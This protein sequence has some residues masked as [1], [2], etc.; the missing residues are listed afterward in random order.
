MY[1]VSYWIN[2]LSN[3]LHEAAKW[4][5]I[6]TGAAMSSIVFLQVFFRFVI[7]IPFPWSEEG[8]RYLMIWMG[9]VGAA[10]AMR[11]GRHIGV[12]VLIERLPPRVC[13]FLSP[14]TDLAMVAFLVVMAKEGFRLAVENA[15][16]Y[17][18]AMNLPMLVPYLAIPIG[19]ALMIL[20]ITASRLQ[21]FFPTEAGSMRKIVPNVQ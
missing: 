15:V 5:L 7:Y 10:T 1:R 19:A 3:V 18:P 20:E 9:M 14:F 16:Q 21:E 13:R 8:A 11:Y 4:F 12:T 2:R 17:S 6:A